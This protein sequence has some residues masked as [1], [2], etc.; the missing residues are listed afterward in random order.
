[1]RNVDTR[2]QRDDYRGRHFLRR[3]RAR[4]YAELGP[5]ETREDFDLIRFNHKGR[6]A[7]SPASGEWFCSRHFERVEGI[8][9]ATA[10]WVW[11]DEE[12]APQEA[13]P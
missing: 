9:R 12:P 10:E 3:V 7:D 5:P 8:Y 13:T 1:M 6:P 4:P 11:A 2:R